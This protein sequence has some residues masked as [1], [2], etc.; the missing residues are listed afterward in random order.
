MSHSMTVRRVAI[1]AA[2]FVLLTLA[3]RPAH[4]QTYFVPFFGFDFGGDAGTCASILS[5]CSVKRNTYGFQVGHLSHGIFGFEADFAYAPDFF[6]DSPTGSNSVLSLMPN[7]VVGV[8]AGPVRPYVTGGLGL[9][10]TKVELN[11]ESL[12]STSDTA[13]GYNIGGG[14]MIFF[15]SHV[16]VRVDYR[17]VRSASDFTVASVTVPGTKL[18]FSRVVFGLVLH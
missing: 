4:A 6:G 3:A 18:S 15:P 10:R 1:A 7:L 17:N 12:L 2:L 14:V 11:L 13:F 8:P 5:D 16:G 9:I